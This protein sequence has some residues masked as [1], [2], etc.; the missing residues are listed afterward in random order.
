MGKHFRMGTMLTREI[1]AKRLESEEGLSFTEFS[2]QLLQGNDFRE[3]HRRY[4]ATLQTGGS[5]QWGNLLAGVELIR[6]AE[7]AA[8]HALTTPLITKAD[9]TK[10]GKT[11][12]GAVWLAPDMMTPY[13][14]YQYW[15]NASDED[16]ARWLR[17]FTFRSRE[18]IEAITAESAEKPAARLAQRTLAGDVTTLVHGESATTAVQA[19]SQALFGRGEL[20]DLPAE[21]V[22]AAVSELP[23]AEVTLG[24][25]T[26][27]D[28]FVASGL[29]KGRN[30]ARRTLAEGGVY[31]NNVKQD[32]GDRV[33]SA[34]DLLS[35][36]RHI[37][38]R[39]GRRVLGAVSV[40]G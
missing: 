37:L 25:T 27:L 29:V 24:S 23:R 14:F 19:A 13:A 31:V 22:D 36:G 28:A 34:E 35:G 38:L 20:R 26:V 1:V 12:G 4:G 11:E 2:Y 6:K 5:D 7:G 17:T 32:D 8:V 3:L 10:F 40:T 18:E 9:G 33:L 30:E 21:V 39:R 15:V 16:A